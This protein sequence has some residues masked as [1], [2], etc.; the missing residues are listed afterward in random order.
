MT[1][2]YFSIFYFYSINNFLAEPC[3]CLW[4]GDGVL[5]RGGRDNDKWV[6]GPLQGH[7]HRVH[8]AGRKLTL[9]QNQAIT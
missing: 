8:E 1:S 3:T 6:L 2:L 5:N 9:S 7:P 4:K